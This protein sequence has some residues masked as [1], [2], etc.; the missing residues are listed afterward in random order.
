M[1]SVLLSLYSNESCANLAAA[2]ASLKEQTVLPNELIAVFDGPLPSELEKVF[3]DSLK[4]VGFPVNIVRL[5]KNSG[6]GIALAAGFEACRQDYILRMDTDDINRPTRIENQLIF[7]KRNPQV[8]AFGCWIEEFNVKPG[9]L[10]RC[11]CTP[12][13][14][15]AVRTFSKKRNPM[16]H[17][18]M[19]MRRSSAV[20]AGGYMDYPGFEDYYLWFRMLKN[21]MVLE[22]MPEV[23]V[24]A[25]VGD[26]MTG[27]RRGIEYLRREIS[28][29]SE[30]RR[31][32][33]ISDYRYIANIGIRYIWRLAP[34]RMLFIFYGIFL[35]KRVNDKT[36]TA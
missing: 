20:R 19:V 27:R 18:T 7:I 32:G 17:M 1:I 13:S 10:K 30:M 23:L 21:G 29:F 2:L 11:R 5:E 3:F 8:D 25:R 31:C 26:G 24:D 6:L 4:E 34:P 35:R 22:N 16:N 12:I 15:D 36:S 33:F 14:A 9:D 28:L